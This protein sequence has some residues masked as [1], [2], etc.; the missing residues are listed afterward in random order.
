MTKTITT[1]KF[2]DP[3]GPANKA[4][5]VYFAVMS[6]ATD[7]AVVLGLYIGRNFAYEESNKV[8]GCV[9]KG[10]IYQDEF[11]ALG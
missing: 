5:P 11:L 2:Q 10:I 4:N 6:D 7:N 8:N 1:Y 3:M 9:R